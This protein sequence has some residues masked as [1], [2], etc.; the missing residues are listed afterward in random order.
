MPTSQAWVLL[1]L[2]FLLLLLQLLLLLLLLLLLTA[3]TTA[4]TTAAVA[5]TSAATIATTTATVTATATTMYCCYYYLLLRL[6]LRVPSRCG[7]WAASSTSG[8]R[9][10]HAAHATCFAPRQTEAAQMAKRSGPDGCTQLTPRASRQGKKK[11]HRWR[12]APSHDPL[13]SS[14]CQRRRCLAS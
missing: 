8:P 1:L 4:T 14:S 10:L 12:R 5:T 11:R 3:A 9:W 13:D 2:L 6:Q 7:C